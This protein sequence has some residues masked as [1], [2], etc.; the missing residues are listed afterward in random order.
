[1]RPLSIAPLATSLAGDLLDR[2]ARA[3]GLRCAPAARPIRPPSLD[4]VLRGRAR[5]A[6]P[7]RAG[8]RGQFLDGRFTNAAGSRAYKVYVPARYHGQALPL[9]VM[10]HGCTQSPDDF[11]AGTRMNEAAEA[12]GCF[13]AYP[14]QTAAANPQRCWNWFNAA[15]Q[16]RDA[17]RAVADRRHHARNDGATTRIDPRA[18]V[19]RRAVGRGRHGGDHGP[20]LSRPLRR[21][22]R[23]FGS[24]QRGGAA[25][26]HRRSPRCAQ[27][28]CRP[29]RRRHGARAD[30]RVPRRPRHH[31]ASAQRR[32]GRS[33]RRV[34]PGR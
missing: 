31:R 28:P 21:G 27:R 2:Q 24:G 11:A 15:E 9:V 4:R 3:P 12:H 18:G 30:D 14:G 16:Q 23:A 6:R 8:E 22:R 10:L 34:P 13:V 26:C 1:M 32:G 19:R 17:R 25:T 29:R 7:G 20:C 33:R 5:R